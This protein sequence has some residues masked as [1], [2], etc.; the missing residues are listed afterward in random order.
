MI[1]TPLVHLGVQF[2]EYR[3]SLMGRTIT[4]PILRVGKGECDYKRRFTVSHDGPYAHTDQQRQHLLG[5]RALYEALLVGVGGH[6][7][8]RR[9]LGVGRVLRQ[10]SIQGLGAMAQL[11]LALEEGE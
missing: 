8:P 10:A 3:Q 9:S 1:R 5:P 6:S 4:V 11:C 2:A 7:N